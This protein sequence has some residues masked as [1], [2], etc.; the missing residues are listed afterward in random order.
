MFKMILSILLWLAIAIN[1]LIGSYM[2]S[3]LCIGILIY[4]K[5]S[6]IEDKLQ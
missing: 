1:T 4:F 6:E 3:V 5:L 2:V